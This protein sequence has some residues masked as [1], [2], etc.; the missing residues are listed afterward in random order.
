MDS[1]SVTTDDLVFSVAAHPTSSQLAVGSITGRVA[2]YAPTDVDGEELDEVFSLQHSECCRS[3]CYSPSG[4][5]LYSASK[6]R[7]LYALNSEDGKEM[8][9]VASAVKSPVN[10][11][12][13]LSDRLICAHDNGVVSVYEAKDLAAV[14]SLHLTEGEEYISGMCH[15]PSGRQLVVST[16]EGQIALIDIRELV[17]KKKFY[18]KNELLCVCWIEG[19]KKC[20]AGDTE[21]RIHFFTWLDCPLHPYAH[22]NCASETSVDSCEQLPLSLVCVGCGD[23]VVRIVNTL[24]LQVLGVVGRRQKMHIAGL[25]VSSPLGM[26]CCS[27]GDKV[28]LWRT[29]DILSGVEQIERKRNQRED[30]ENPEQRKKGRVDAECETEQAVRSEPAKEGIVVRGLRK[31]KKKQKKQKYDSRSRRAMFFD[32]LL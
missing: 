30:D 32:G 9:C 19:E 17:L 16:G 14:G 31:G 24:S 12:L 10:V 4:D 8:C 20:I 23:G 1:V 15:T 2:G 29:A 5:I 21:G 6:D 3:L 11:M 26:L 25:V 13:C 18:C 28:I 27:T 7:H 22:V